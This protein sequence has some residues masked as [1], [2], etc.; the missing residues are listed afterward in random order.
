MVALTSLEPVLVSALDISDYVFL[1]ASLVL[2]Y[3]FDQHFDSLKRKPPIKGNEM[4]FFFI[5]HYLLEYI[6]SFLQITLGSIFI[7]EY[8]NYKYSGR[9]LNPHDCNSHWILSPTCLPIPPPERQFER[10]TGFE[11]ATLTLARLCSTPEL[12]SQNGYK[13][14]H[15]LRQNFKHLFSEFP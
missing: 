14:K 7:L 2:F 8:Y 5:R 6:L 9:D 3:A 13:F 11:P 10:K 4:W 12:L 1:I 15:L